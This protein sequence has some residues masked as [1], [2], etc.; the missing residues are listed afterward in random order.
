[1][2]YWNAAVA[3][4]IATVTVAASA[5][6]PTNDGAA[7]T[8]NL[9]MTVGAIFEIQAVTDMPEQYSWVLTRDQQFVEASRSHVYQ[10]RFTQAGTYVLAAQITHDDG[11]AMAAR[12]FQITVRPRRPEDGVLPETD[13]INANDIVRFTPA[14]RNG[15]IALGA[16]RQLLLATPSREDIAVIA[17]DFDVTQDENGDG[18]ASN[19][20]QTRDTLFRSNTNALYMWFPSARSRNMKA[21]ALLRNNTTSIQDFSLQFGDNPVQNEESS[22]ASDQAASQD[23]AQT[24][25]VL[26]SDNGTLQF[27]VR[28]DTPVDAGTVLYQWNFGDGSQSLLDRPI[29][30]F[31]EAGTYKVSVSVRDLKTG[32]ENFTIS[33]SIVVNRLMEEASSNSS[34]S[35]KENPTPQ[36]SGTSVGLLGIVIRGILGLLISAII[37]AGAVFV[38]G[39]MKKKG[40]SLQKTM[41]NA[42]KKIVGKSAQASPEAK[43]LTMEIVD[44]MPAPPSETAQAEAETG[45]QKEEETP[46]WMND[47]AAAPEP[48]K[49]ATPVSANDE[50]ESHTPMQPS[51]AQLEADIAKAPSWLKSGIETAAAVGQTPTAPPP[52]EL[53]TEPAADAA[54]PSWLGYNPANQTPTPTPLPAVAAEPAPIV[55]APVIPTPVPQT[56]A[57]PP[58]TP[59]GAPAPQSKPAASTQPA[60]DAE[61]DEQEEK[62]DPSAPADPEREARIREKKRLKRQR[63]RENKKQRD[64]AAKAAAPAPAAP[65]APAAPAAPNP[66]PPTAAPAKPEAAAIPD[67]QTVAIVRADDV[68]APKQSPTPPPPPPPGAKHPEAKEGGEDD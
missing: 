37:G 35:E 12:N 10:T 1:M 53:E 7:G 22:G 57:A 42:E 39:K 51:A 16:E 48:A 5:Q 62:V 50:T 41:E 15:V 11:T 45:A 68:G 26:K 28:S 33:D 19:D 3:S 4:I 65:T 20:D 40:L 18:N 60:D 2:K 67:D 31:A 6:M 49:Q 21:G 38:V 55:P 17:V 23:A 64:G 58:P 54:T 13:A 27:T 24:I 36:S 63:Y 46:S 66:V 44:D 34:A 9:E 25:T 43:H 56:P 59:A 52:P 14:A 30:T 61:G 47:A 32:A 29:H 8:E